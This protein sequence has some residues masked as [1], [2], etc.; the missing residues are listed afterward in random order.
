M[1]LDSLGIIDVINALAPYNYWEEKI[2]VVSVA[3]S[4]EWL[5]CTVVLLH[6]VTRLVSF[7]KTE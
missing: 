4:C 2:N 1:T 5:L 7:Q 3:Y 6:S